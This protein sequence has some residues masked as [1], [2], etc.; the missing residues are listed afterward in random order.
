MLFSWSIIRLLFWIAIPALLLSVQWV[1]YR[2]AARWLRVKY[3][4]VRWPL[5]VLRGLFLLFNSVTLYLALVRPRFT[6]L[7]DWFVYTGV[8][9]YFLWQGST[10]MIALVLLVGALIKSPFSAAL[11]IAKKIPPF[12]RKIQKVE[13]TSTFQKFDSSRR[14]FLRRA[15]YGV[16]AASFGGNAYGMLVE[17]SS[18]E[19][20][21]ATFLLPNLPPQLAGFTITLL[22]DIHSSLYMTR[23]QMEEYVRLANGMN[24]DII[25]VPGDFV[26]NQVDEVYPFA[27]AFSALRAP[28]GVYGVLGN[29]DFYT[30]DPERVARVVDDCGVKLIRNDKIT[31]S[32]GGG[33]FYLIG[34]DDVG[35][36]EH[37]SIK[38][39][40]AIG[41]A[42]RDIPRI[43]LCHRPYYLG[44]AAA[45]NINLV[46]SGHT[47]GGQVVFGKFAGITFAPAAIAS[48]YIWGKYRSGNT[49]MYVS[50]GIGTVGLPV[51][52]NCP[53]EITRIILQ[54]V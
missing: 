20:N 36:D 48:P 42:P 43:L 14:V 10:F 7:P 18:C 22:S 27:E 4:G 32:K 31:I 50:R 45:Q 5:S 25:V 19:L 52:F 24:S 11:A 49:H 30:Q 26:N 12:R 53:P 28:L 47:H 40:T 17:K 46:L 44:Q 2:R 54:P 33:E 34:V 41:Q 15:M 3:P 37:E 8:Y 38:L 6:E 23:R 13:G 1:V 29:H 35:R 16:T 51:R 9:P 39:T 21:E